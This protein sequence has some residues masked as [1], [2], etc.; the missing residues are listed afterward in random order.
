Q[1]ADA[2][3]QLV[4]STL[5]EA[6]DTELEVGLRF[7]HAAEELVPRLGPVLQYVL[8]A[9]QRELTRNDVV[10][11][12]ALA[13]GDLA[14]VRDVTVCFADLVEF[15]RLGEQLMADEL[16]AVTGRFSELAAE[17]A[18]APVR[19]VKLIGDAAMLVSA[20][21]DAVLDSALGLID[22]A[23]EEGEDFPTARAGVARGPAL[24]QG[25][26]WYGHT[27][28][29]A[30]RLTGVAH[31][32]SVLVDKEVRASADEE[33]FRWSNAGRRKLKGISGPVRSFRVRRGDEDGV[34]HARG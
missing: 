13:A 7:A 16:A 18:V 4:R 34:T 11:S 32:G 3:R 1:V 25:G 23:D 20:D 33:R 10:S 21:T 22:E 30:S 29:L 14:G 6:G 26:D 19:L 12:A 27:V 28:N 31:P 5:V 24:P 2:N 9:H 15:T 8:A 17:V